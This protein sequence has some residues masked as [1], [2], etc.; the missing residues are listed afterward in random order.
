MGGKFVAV[1]AAVAAVLAVAAGTAYAQPDPNKVLHAS[2]PTPETGFDPQAAGDEYSNS[3]NR[4]IFDT[5]YRYDYLARPYKLVPNVATGMPE[6]SPDGK[7][8][9]I[10]IRQ[11]IVF[12]DDPVFKGQRREL[13]AGDF[14]YAW[15]RVLDPGM[16]SNSLQSLDGRFVGADAVVANAK[17]TG[18]FDYDAPIEGMQA[19]DRYTIRIKLNFADY[20]L[21]A[22]LTT[23]ATAAIAREVV[24]AYADGAG[25]VMANPVGTG[26]YRLKEWRRGQ[27]IVLEASPT[28]RDEFYPDSSLPEDRAIMAKLRGKKLPLTGRIEIGIIE[29]SNPRLLA[30]E[31]RDL[32]YVTVPPDLVPNVLDA[33]NH[34]KPRFAEQGIVL[35]RGIQ[36]AITYSY[37]N[38]EDP[39]VGGYTPAKIALRRA[40]GMAY[41]VDEEIRVLRAGQAVPATQPIPPGVTGYNPKFDGHA[42]YDPAG[43]RAVLDKFG[44][45]DRDKDGWRDMPDGTPLLLKIAAGT[46][47][48]DR[49]YN[50]LW[51]RNLTAV[52]LR[53]EF[54][55]Q[56]FA[57]NVKA[58]RLGQLQMW[59]LGNINTTT[60]GF[61]FLGLLY[62]GNAGFSNL[63]RFKLP[64]FDR[65]YEEAR[66]MPD[67]PARTKILQRMSELVTIYAPWNLHAFRYENVLV[68]PWVV[69]YK[70]N[71]FDRHPWRYYDIDVKR[72]NAAGK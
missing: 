11:G 27:R 46:S 63:A 60:E 23:V 58:A 56:K 1:V 21:L 57:D 7:T 53:V 72:R 70:Y 4:V 61:G 12:S 38:M 26:P 10:R 66:A 36:P 59:F 25:W 71:A 30:F 42:K 37:F 6:V 8:W 41:N 24:E 43:A 5:L 18:K 28:F 39:V 35:G 17:E 44:Y 65:L 45:V 64:E 62:G 55:N 68:Q 49:Q 50:E 14:I 40:I 32:D 51:K 13:V 52:G 54:L 16:R 48:L 22:N 20:E 15:K 29:E 19:V 34:L 2:F 31:Q 33:A 67:G 47:A 3:V 9:T 69:G